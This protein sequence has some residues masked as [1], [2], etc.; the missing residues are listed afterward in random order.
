VWSAA[1]GGSKLTSA[2]F[3][4][5]SAALKAQFTDKT[6][7]F[8][9]PQA[10]AL[11]GKR[12]KLYAPA[13]WSGGSSISHLDEAAFPTGGVN[14]L[15]TPFLANG[16][17]I[18]DP[19]PLTLAMFRDIGWVTAPDDLP[20]LTIGN[21]KK[22]EGDS[23]TKALTFKLQLSAPAQVPVKITWATSDGKA[24]NPKD[25]IAA[26]GTVT[27]PAGAS[28]GTI[29]VMVKGDTKVEPAETFTV[30]LS[31][32]A[33]ATVADGVGMGTIKNDD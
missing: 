29:Q 3:A 21:V 19:G 17:V 4:N 24:K 16:E 15:M 12:P 30:T 23:G 10:T 5:P 6:V 20:A 25:Y 7:F 2:A 1:S 8:G 27:I 31:G 13:T 33:G 28:T 9:G 11:L 32:V 14:S 26:S 18:A 22:P